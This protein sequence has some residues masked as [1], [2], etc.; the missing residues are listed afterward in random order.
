MPIRAT[1]SPGS[2][3]TESSKEPGKDAVSY[4]WGQADAAIYNALHWE[5]GV[6]GRLWT[7]WETGTP[8]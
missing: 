7:S 8:E 3:C 6:I 2:C 1:L 5:W 4:F